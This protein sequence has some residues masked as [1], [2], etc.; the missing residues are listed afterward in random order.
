MNEE[1]LGL[2]TS[3]VLIRAEE[4]TKSHKRPITYKEAMDLMLLPLRK[5]KFFTALVG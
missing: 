3:G 2:P 4:Y 5:M 1:G